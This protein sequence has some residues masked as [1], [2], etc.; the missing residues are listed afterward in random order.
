MFPYFY[1]KNLSL[2]RKK[3]VG[4]NSMQYE[5]ITVLQEIWLPRQV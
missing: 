1:S 5:V 4:L 2:Q 3:A